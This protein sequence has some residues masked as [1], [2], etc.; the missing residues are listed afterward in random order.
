MQIFNEKIPRSTV[1]FLLQVMCVYKAHSTNN[2]QD[3]MEGERRGEGRGEG[4]GREG[5]RRGKGRGR[6]EGKGGGEERGRREGRRG[7]GGEGG[8]NFCAKIPN[9]R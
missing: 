8:E 5:E 9:L 6:G 7:K 3:T 1:V 4:K 2:N